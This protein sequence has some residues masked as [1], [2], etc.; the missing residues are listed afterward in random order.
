MPVNPTYPGVYIEE[1]PSGVRTITGV[2][3]SITAFIGRAKRGP[4]NEPVT[5]NS[6]SD[7]ERSF[8][9]L[10]TGSTLGYAV[11]DFYRNG[12]SQAVVVRLFSPYFASDA[13]RVAALAAATAV[14]D[15]AK[16]GD[17]I[18]DAKADA[19]AAFDLINGDGAKSAAEK[20]AAKTVND[21]VQAVAATGT[22]MTD[23]NAAADAG[24]LLAVP[25]AKAHVTLGTLTL[26]AAYEGSWGGGLK[27]TADS[28][29]RSPSD[30]KLFNLT[31]ED[32]SGNQEK[33]LNVS[34]DPAAPRFLPTVLEQQSRLARVQKTGSTWTIGA[35]RPVSLPATAS[36]VGG[37][38]GSALTSTVVTGSESGKTGLYALEKTDLFNLLCIPPYTAAGDIDLTVVAAAAT[39]CEKRRAMLVL[40]APTG[41]VGKDAAKTGVS[42]VGTTSKNAAVFFPR[43]L[44]Q[45]PVR[46][47]QVE[48]FAPCGAV[49]GVF[50]RTDAQR[51]VWKAPAG[52]DAALN[53]TLGPAVPLTDGENGELNPLGVN[54]LRTMPAAGTVV[55]G[56]RTLQGNDRLASEWKYIPVR[57]TA[58]FIEESLY[59][60]TQCVVFEPNDEPLWSQIRL[61]IGSFMHSMFRQGAF[62]GTT[63]KDAYFVK[64]D[65]E[66]T[67][68]DDVNKGI[69][70]IVVGFAP[71]KPAEFVIIKLQQMAG[72]VQA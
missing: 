10:W 60:G 43:L 23:I 53:G 34:S 48:V 19:T 26:E 24:V 47:N 46:E 9:G 5:V 36:G 37:D 15:A 38:D 27:A 66:T 4:V 32:G 20:L 42:S 41:W 31:V 6:Y 11:Q 2:A 17:S 55:W 39:Y 22:T 59:R 52:L 33:F 25:A 68:Q 51:G 14:A 21:K 8:G 3:T 71:L 45:N 56:A 40:D 64:C 18:A 28:D 7:F 72:Q 58:L 70:N 44:M 13:E 57:R 49:A 35:E 1:V 12:G 67:T 50:A 29:T 54:C 63:P 61:N 30:T 65:K 16:G 69:V 62:Q